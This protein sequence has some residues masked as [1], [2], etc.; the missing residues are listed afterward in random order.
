[1]QGLIFVTWD[2]FLSE[3]F[4]NSAAIDASREAMKGTEAE[5]AL[6][7]RIYDDE[8]I[9]NAVG[10]VSQATGIPAPALLRMYG[11]YFINNN[12][13]NHLCT[14]LLSQAHSA[15][16]LLLIMGDAHKQMRNTSAKNSAPLFAYASLSGDSDDLLIRY[17]SHR[18]LCPVLVGAVQ[19]ASDLYY[20]KI[21]I[22]ERSCMQHGDAAC[23]MEIRFDRKT[24]T[25]IDLSQKNRE[26]EQ[27]W[28][29]D[30]VLYSLSF[31]ERYTLSD[32]MSI[33]RVNPAM[34]GKYVRPSFII[35][36]INR[37]HHAGLVASTADSGDALPARR[38]WRVD[39]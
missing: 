26:S 23:L 29:A 22:H 12:L 39:V 3:Q 17:D 16:D 27:R 7:S 1:M 36:A 11:R 30:I 10:A 9:V 34:P 37:L 13:T 20:E 32:V 31:R 4:S 5:H 21:E 35:N 6:T 33:L 8:I 19:G 2:H 38:Y 24:E 25:L 14:Y 18:K 15:R 28:M